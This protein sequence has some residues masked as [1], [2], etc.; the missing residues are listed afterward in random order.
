MKI[1][2]L[3]EGD[4]TGTSPQ[5][6]YHEIIEEVALADKL[7]FSTWGTSEQHFNPPG[8]TVSAPE[9]L[10]AAVAMRTE[11]IILRP[12]SIVLLTWNHPIQIAERYASLDIISKGRAE[13][14]LARSNSVETMKIFGVDP[15]KTREIFAENL[16][17]LEKIFTDPV[18]EHQGNYWQ[19]PQ[20]QVTPTCVDNKFPKLSSA[21]TSVV[22][23]ENMGKSGYGVISFDSYFGWD[24][25][26]ECL[27][28]YKTGWENR[29]HASPN[30]N[31]TFG[32]YVATA[33][34]APTLAEA[35]EVADEQALAYFD[36]VIRVNTSLANSP[37]YEY[38]G[39]IENF[40]AVRE[41][42]KASDWLKE[43]TAS[44]MIGTPDDYIT[45]LKDLEARGVDEVLLR[46]DGFG[47]DKIMKTI[48]LIGKEVIPSVS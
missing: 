13:L 33:F 48:E 36:E 41:G 45:R 32:V 4:S 29:N 1:G 25:T 14:C 26:D 21:A 34:C 19:F 28:A 42:G 40:K 37:G 15:S 10:Y 47:H 39:H 46:I 2:L 6:R 43:S 20:I 8:W 44:V 5:V 27:A 30:Q 11:R 23:H 9:V 24:Y 16:E 18:V 35:A 22:S 31:N 38:M 12:M 7:G 17:I 3:Q